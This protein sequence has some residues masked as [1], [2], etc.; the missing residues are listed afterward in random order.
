MTK[1]NSYFTFTKKKYATHKSKHHNQKNLSKLATMMHNFMQ[2]L[3]Y[4]FTKK[5]TSISITKPTF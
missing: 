5:K 4:E 3:S 2:R 1:N